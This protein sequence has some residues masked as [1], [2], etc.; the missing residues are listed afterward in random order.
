MHFQK[1]IIVWSYIHPS[2]TNSTLLTADMVLL[3]VKNPVPNS[4]FS[5]PFP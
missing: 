1:N 4:Q 2:T 5:F 3:R